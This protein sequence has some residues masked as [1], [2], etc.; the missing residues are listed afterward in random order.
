VS[1]AETGIDSPGANRVN[2][3][4]DSR[5]REVAYG[6]TFHAGA[7]ANYLVEHSRT[8]ILDLTSTV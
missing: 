1:Q 6:D 2:S 7:M 5:C 4:F 8:K 3:V